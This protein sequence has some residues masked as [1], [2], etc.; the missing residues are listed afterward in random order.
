MARTVKAATAPL[1]A[2]VAALEGQRAVEQVAEADLVPAFLEELRAAIAA[3]AAIDFKL[4][5][6][7]G[8]RKRIVRDRNG[9]IAEIVEEPS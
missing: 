7:P 4:L 1:A 2:R 6:A 8:V 3:P 9:R 5:P